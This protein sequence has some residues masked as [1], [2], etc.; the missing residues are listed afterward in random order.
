VTN[1]L[2]GIAVVV[3]P[4]LGLF[5]V[6]LLVVP[7]L[8]SLESGA[9]LVAEEAGMDEDTS[10]MPITQ[11]RVQVPPTTGGEICRRAGEV[12]FSGLKFTPERSS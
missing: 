5:S 11:R 7:P 6:P 2:P 8:P 12:V 3:V 10:A 1:L 9:V 4:G